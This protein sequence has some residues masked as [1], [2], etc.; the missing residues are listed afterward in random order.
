MKLIT[1]LTNFK[2]NILKG[3]LETI[4]PRDCI[5]TP[6]ISTVVTFYAVC[7]GELVFSCS[8]MKKACVVGVLDQ[9]HIIYMPLSNEDGLA[10]GL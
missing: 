3:Y 6:Y 8:S 7:Y 5:H 9:N 2:W 4:I 1:K 10:K